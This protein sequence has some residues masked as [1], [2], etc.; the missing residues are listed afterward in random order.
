MSAAP[1]SANTRITTHP[2]L[3]SALESR[4]NNY[5]AVRLMAAIAVIVSHSYLILRPGE[6]VEPLSWSAYNLGATAVNVFFVLSGAMISRSYARHPDLVRFIKARLLRIYPGLIVA[7]LVTA[8]LIVP[9]A[10]EV[11]ATNYLTAPSTWFYP[12]QVTY[13]FADA[14][15]FDAF[16]HNIREDTNAPLWTIRYELFAYV[17]FAA[18]VL[19]GIVDRKR[20]IMVAMLGSGIFLGLADILY[21]TATLPGALLRFSFA[22][23]IGVVAFQ[24]ADRIHLSIGL[25]IISIV[26]SFALAG[27]PGDKVFSILLFGYAALTFGGATPSVLPIIQRHDLSY[28]IYL[29]GWPIQQG[30]SHHIAWDGPLIFAHMAIALVCASGLAVISWF[31]VEKPALSIR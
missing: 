28:G 6:G 29:Y 26:L 17:C 15:L 25:A 23:L 3:A 13:D 27:F 16:T 4:D 21:L 1:P 2:T 31:F 12:L 9:F 20:L 7:S 24:W 5:N 19:W 10:T 8:V 14:R 18:L 11:P 22:F 30:I